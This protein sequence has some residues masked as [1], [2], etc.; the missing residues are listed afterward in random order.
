MRLYEWSQTCNLRHA[1]EPATRWSRATVE[2]PIAQAVLFATLDQCCQ[3]RRREE[4]K[5]TERRGAR[6]VV[7]N[8]RLGLAQSIRL[9]VTQSGEAWEVFKLLP[10]LLWNWRAS[11]SEGMLNSSLFLTTRRKPAIYAACPGAYE[12]VPPSSSGCSLFS[13]HSPLPYLELL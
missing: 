12:T 4:R 9:L 11:G 2:A 10:F 1:I 5:Q 6:Q 3:E 8:T 13:T 7:A